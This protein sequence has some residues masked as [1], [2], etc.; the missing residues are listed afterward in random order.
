MCPCS[1]NFIL[2]VQV[3][4]FQLRRIAVPPS[5]CIHLTDLATPTTDSTHYH[6]SYSPSFNLNPLLSRFV[7]INHGSNC[8]M[9]FPTYSDD[10]LSRMHLVDCPI[11]WKLS[12]R[13]LAPNIHETR[14]GEGEERYGNRS[15]T[16]I[17]RLIHVTIVSMYRVVLC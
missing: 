4:W 16:F 11:N 3:T 15:A 6:H 5:K 2:S 12:I 17:R 7:Q 9:S 1:R 10:T 14:R 13:G 8:S